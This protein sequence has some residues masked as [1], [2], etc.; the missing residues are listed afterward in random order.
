MP[1]RFTSANPFRWLRTKAYHSAPGNH[2][3]TDLQPLVVK[4]AFLHFANIC[5]IIFALVQ[6]TLLFVVDEQRLLMKKAVAIFFLFLLC[7]QAVPVLHFF[8]SQKS[9]FYSYVDE[10]KPAE[11][12]MKEKAD[13]KE[14]LSPQL[15]VV[16]LEPNPVAHKSFYISSLPSPYLESFTP[17]PDFTCSCTD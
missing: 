15:L 5:P 1:W 13:G 12:K 4:S 3:R 2:Q 10:D 16:T 6:P 17:P 14:F 8:S 9:I 7:L 11:A